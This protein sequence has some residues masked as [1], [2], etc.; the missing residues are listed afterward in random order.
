MHGRYVLSVPQC[1][2]R[3]GCDEEI[4]KLSTDAVNFDAWGQDR[5]WQRRPGFISKWMVNTRIYSRYVRYIHRLLILSGFSLKHSHLCVG[6]GRKGAFNGFPTSQTKRTDTHDSCRSCS[7]NRSQ[8]K[9][10]FCTKGDQSNPSNAFK[11]WKMAHATDI[12]IPM[13]SLVYVY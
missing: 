3:H 13:N 10:I 4:A 6:V 8:S 9:C 11:K 5:Q 12:Q 1:P 2:A 7:L